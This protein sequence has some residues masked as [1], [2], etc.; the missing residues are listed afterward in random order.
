MTFSVLCARRMMLVES[1]QKLF[2]GWLTLVDIK[3]LKIVNQASNYRSFYIDDSNKKT[4]KVPSR[5]RM[6]AAASYFQFEKHLFR[7]VRRIQYA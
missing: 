7:D 5:S 4:L 6:A 1:K 3:C 2:G